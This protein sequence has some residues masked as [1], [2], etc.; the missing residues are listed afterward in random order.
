MVEGDVWQL[1]VPAALAGSMENKPLN[2][3]QVSMMLP[4]GVDLVVRLQLI[5]IKGSRLKAITC[6]PVSLKHC[7][8][9][10]KEYAAQWQ[11]GSLEQIAVELKRVQEEHRAQRTNEEKQPWL[12]QQ[13]GILVKL[14]L[15]LLEQ[16]DL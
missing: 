7:S 4:A 8:E 11:G 9:R 6:E 13:V 12:Q 10:E 2:K 1:H 14:K 5:Y 16:N 3:E 15:L